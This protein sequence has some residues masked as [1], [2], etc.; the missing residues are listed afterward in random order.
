MEVE[1]E[2]EKDT[3]NTKKPRGVD[4]QQTLDTDGKLHREGCSV[5]EEQSDLRWYRENSE[6]SSDNCYRLCTEHARDFLENGFVKEDNMC[7]VMF[8]KAINKALDKLGK[9]GIGY[10]DSMEL[11]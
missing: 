1:K 9:L 4:P 2:V 3:K 10:D 11:S 8:N 5:C 6:N 7:D